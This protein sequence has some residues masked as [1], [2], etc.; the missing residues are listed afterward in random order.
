METKEELV[1]GKTPPEISRQFFPDLAGAVTAL[2]AVLPAALMLLT[3]AYSDTAVAASTTRPSGKTFAFER[4]AQVN[5]AGADGG[6]LPYSR[7]QVAGAWH[8][9]IGTTGRI[10]LRRRPLWVGPGGRLFVAAEV[11]VAQAKVD[12]KLDIYVSRDGVWERRGE[13]AYDASSGSRLVSTTLIQPELPEGPIMT[14][15]HVRGVHRS[16][17]QEIESAPIAIPSGARMRLGLGLEGVDPTRA[18]PLEVVVGVRTS[19][20]EPR[21]LF[22]SKIEPNQGASSW[23]NIEL[24]LSRVAGA[25]GRFVFRSRPMAVDGPAPGVIWGAPTVYYEQQRRSFP[26]VL[27][28]SLDSLRPETLGVYGAASSPSP[29]I[30]FYFGRQGTT[31]TSARSSAATTLP[32]HM[33]LMTSLNPCVHAVTS[34]K[35]RLGSKVTTLPELF[36]RSGWRTAAFTDGG[37]LASEFGFGRGFEVYDE[38]AAAPFPAA[39]SASN[40]LDRAAEW[41]RHH[42]GTPAFLFVHSY[43]TRPFDFGSST[44]GGTPPPGYRASVAAADASLRRLVD[45]LNTVGVRD[46]SVVILTSG[47]GEEFGEHGARGHGTHLYEE[48]LHIPLLFAGGPI[49]GG[50]R[51]STVASHIDMAPTILDLA[52]IPVPK[53]MQGRSLAAELEGRSAV[54]TPY[55]FSEAHRDRRLTVDGKVKAWSSPGFAVRDGQYKAIREGVGRSSTVK[56]FDLA[57]DPLERKNAFAAR[58]PPAWARKLSKVLDNYPGI[59][60]RLAQ[61]TGGQPNLDAEDRRRLRALGYLQ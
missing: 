21:V 13:L 34:E 28:V 60:R 3:V 52:K 32:A 17:W 19:K 1:I 44:V 6:A 35:T 16:E 26:V 48:T 29:F 36:K 7:M 54:S 49:R 9:I 15:V 37:A 12:R 51:S 23:R 4:R 33:S 61:K 8:D 5:P 55:R 45:T 42:D 39:R 57:N 59:C 27:V 25:T 18:V 20:G 56:A 46:R 40:S 14:E 22:S 50:K 47:H 10:A 30:D 2:S 24:D 38:G 53:W 58:N 11:P 41:L 31:F 43:A